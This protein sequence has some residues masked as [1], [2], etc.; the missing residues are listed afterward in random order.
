[1]SAP[2]L[3]HAD[4]VCTRKLYTRSTGT[5]GVLRGRLAAA[6]LGP[7]LRVP[8]V[9]RAIGYEAGVAIS[10]VDDV[11]LRVESHGRGRGGGFGVAVGQEPRAI[12]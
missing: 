5:P 9:C 2:S 7:S 10:K 4:L 8:V 6:R 1:M 11:D 3:R 12:R